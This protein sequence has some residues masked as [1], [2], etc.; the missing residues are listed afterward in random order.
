M[1]IKVKK[2]LEDAKL[3]T[4][5]YGKSLGY[6]LYHENSGTCIDPGGRVILRTGI[7]IRSP[8]DYGG[9]LKDRSGLAAMHGLHILGGVI[10]PDYRGEI[11]VIMLNTGDAPYYVA[12]GEKIAQF[13]PVIMPVWGI[14]EVDE[15]DETERGEKG[16]GSSGR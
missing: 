7:A 5:S 3:P 16:L 9:F 11:K 14:R 8:G 15:L 4:R 13:V 12:P 1:D 10:D 2:L 6:D